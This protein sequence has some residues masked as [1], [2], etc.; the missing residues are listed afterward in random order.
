MTSASSR[1]DTFSCT[2]TVDAS[3]G[4]EQAEAFARAGGLSLGGVVDRC[5]GETVGASLARRQWLPPLWP[6]HT[7]WGACISFSANTRAD[8]TYRTVRAP[9]TSSGPDLRGLWVGGEGRWGQIVEATFQAEP[10]GEVAWL[11]GERGAVDATA[12]RRVVD[13]FGSR[14][15]VRGGEV[16]WFARVRE[17][18]R[19]AALA[20]ERLVAAGLE[21]AESA[22]PLCVHP[23]LVA[24]V[25]WAT[26]ASVPDAL[27]VL[28]A[29]PTHV[30]VGGA[31]S[32][33]LERWV[34]GVASP[35]ARAVAA[36]SPLHDLSPFREPI[37]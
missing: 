33:A 22:P 19:V 35:V 23:A 26:L 18:G 31:S 29:G 5:A 28:A 30:A 36:S 14:V 13:A 3:T 10:V 1:V 11:R 24:C 21:P 9:R 4:W 15:T 17:G 6:A 27:Y 37:A 8:T 20:V 2:V 25:P 12:L 32:P 34:S 7:V 16:A